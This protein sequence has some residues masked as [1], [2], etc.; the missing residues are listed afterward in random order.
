MSTQITTGLFQNVASTP[1]FIP[2]H[3]YISEIRLKNLTSSGVTVG[4]V[5]GALTSDRIVEAFWCDYMNAG[6]AQVIQNGT[7]ATGLAPQSVGN[8]AANG[9]TVFNAAKQPVFAPVAVAS[10]VP[11]TP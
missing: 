11:G 8:L 1:F 6:T 3:Q 5:A 7:A 2:L 10:F 9:I 4:S